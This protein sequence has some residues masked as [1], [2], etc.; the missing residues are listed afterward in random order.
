MSLLFILK[1]RDTLQEGIPINYFLN[2]AFF[3]EEVEEV[4][5]TALECESTAWS[6]AV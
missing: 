4:S 3:G 6:F 1:N 2:A 5:S